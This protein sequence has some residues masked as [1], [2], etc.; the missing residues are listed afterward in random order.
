MVLGGFPGG[1]EDKESACN[2]EDLGLVPGSGRSPGEGNSN[3][4]QCSCLENSMDRGAW[5]ATVYGIAK[6]WTQLSDELFHFL[7]KPKFL[8]VE[9]RG[10]LGNFGRNGSA[11]LKSGNIFSCFLPRTCIY[12]YTI[13]SL[14]CSWDLLFIIFHQRHHLLHRPSGS[15]S[16]LPSRCI[17][18][19]VNQMM[20]FKVASLPGHLDD[21]CHSYQWDLFNSNIYSSELWSTA[22]KF[23]YGGCFRGWGTALSPCFNIIRQSQVSGL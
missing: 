13:P 16:L 1:S 9:S 21:L 5:W 4:L 2:A 10:R 14:F 3:P 6:S 8:L 17:S 18:F 11:F 23:N 7:I 15:P 19:R 20:I 22:L 12:L